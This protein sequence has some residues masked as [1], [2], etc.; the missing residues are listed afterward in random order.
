VK[1][2]DGLAIR[3]PPLG[4]TESAA[5]AQR[6]GLIDLICTH[7]PILLSCVVDTYRF[8]LYAGPKWPKDASLC[9]SRRP[10]NTPQA[11][12]SGEEANYRSFSAGIYSSAFSMTSVLSVT[13]AAMAP[14]AARVCNTKAPTTPCV[15]GISISVSPLTTYSSC[16]NL[17]FAHGS[18]LAY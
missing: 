18:P 8:A 9:Q 14:I 3:V 6:S 7:D 15:S 5:V 4:L 17:F 16:S 2:K 11:S 1:V 13:R 10:A 12:R